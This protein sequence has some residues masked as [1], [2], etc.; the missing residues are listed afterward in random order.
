MPW[1]E[2]VN[3]GG[4]ND[5]IIKSG[6]NG[7]TLKPNG[8]AA[9]SGNLDVG[10]SQ[11]QASIKAYVNHAGHQ[12]NVEIEA[13]WNSQG[14]IHFNTTNPDCLLLIATKDDIY[15]YCGLNIIYFY[16]PTTNASDDRL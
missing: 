10:A 5:F 13:R 12:G 6:S 14:F 1:Q 9:I 2:G 16:K 7:L 4:S 15:L 3:W 11:A 8:S